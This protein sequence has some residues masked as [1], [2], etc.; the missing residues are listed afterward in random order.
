[1][2]RLYSG[3]AVKV[4][5]TLRLLFHLALRQAEAFARSVVRWL[6][7]TLQVPDHTTLSRR[8]GSFAGR[9]HRSAWHDG[10]VYFMLDSSGLKP[11]HPVC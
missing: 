6:R 7:V 2:Q 3:L 4:V 5:L 8:G 1:M 11:M 10:S 9:Q